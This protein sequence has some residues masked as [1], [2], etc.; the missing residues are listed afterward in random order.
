MCHILIGKGGI[1]LIVENT[2]AYLQTMP[3]LISKIQFNIER[4]MSKQV[5]IWILL[6]MQSKK[7][8]ALPKT[9]VCVRKRIPFGL[10]GNC[11]H[12]SVNCWENGK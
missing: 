12:A 2:G 5:F 8:Y 10:L 9:N 1:H 3:L 11:F 4:Q 7:P 6:L